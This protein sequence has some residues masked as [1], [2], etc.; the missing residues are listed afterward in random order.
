MNKDLENMLATMKSFDPAMK[1]KF[2]AVVNM[3]KYHSPQECTGR[4][5]LIAHM[6][7]FD[8]EHQELAL[9]YLAKM[10]IVKTPANAGVL[11]LELT[12]DQAYQV[13]ERK[14]LFKSIQADRIM[15]VF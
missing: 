12:A 10:G 15:T 2:L 7:A 6:K 13:A 3:P 4:W 9:A 5:D 8:A 11:V 14:D 1:C